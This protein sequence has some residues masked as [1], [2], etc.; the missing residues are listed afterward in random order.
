MLRPKVILQLIESWGPGGAEK[1][2][3]E[4]C[5][6][7]DKKHFYPVVILLHDGWLYDKL[8]ESGI[9]AIVV[10]N[11]YS[12]DPLFLWELFGIIRKF[13]VD[14]IHSH[15]F[16]MN[17]YGSLAG[18]LTGIPVIATVHGKKYF[19]EHWR[20]RFAYRVTARFSS[21]IAVSRDL[22]QFISEKTGASGN[23]IGVIYNGINC[24]AYGNGDAASLRKELGLA[25]GAP[26]IGM[27][28]N[29]YKVKGYP[30]FLQAAREILKTFP[31]AVFLIVG[32]GE[33]QEALEQQAA[34]LGLGDSI[35]FLGFREDIPDLLNLIDI[36]VLSSLS[37]GLSLSILEAMAAGKPVVATNVGGNPEVIVEGSTGFLVPV[38]D[39]EALARRI[40]TF[41]SD[42][43]SARGMGQE[44]RKRVLE[45]FSVEAMTMR[46]QSLYREL[47]G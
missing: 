18:L 3:L 40:M 39:P 21:M 23:K 6:G 2:L 33:L 46:Y 11:K 22:K 34:E 16:M 41:L 8:K 27:I 30:F 12:Y 15:E 5:R 17:V 10:S 45:N 20:R 38:G 25:S 44:A 28:G 37:E 42:P 1:V 19:H 13:K 29:L 26:V 7:V 47:A 24:A 36:F 31:G 9:E 4:L 32:R 43:G 14:I 35:R